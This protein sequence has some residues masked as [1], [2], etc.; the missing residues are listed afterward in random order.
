QVPWRREAAGR[1]VAP[2]EVLGATAER[3]L[4]EVCE[5]LEALTAETPLVLVLEDLHWSDLSTVDLI[6]ALARR[7]QPARL[8]LVATYRPVEAILSD[9]PLRAVKQAL[10][11][12]GLCREVP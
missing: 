2:R 11:T 6:P 9:H 10:L 3:M 7:R 8:L 1:D 5:A 4:R 12:R